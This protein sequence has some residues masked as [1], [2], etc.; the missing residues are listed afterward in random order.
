MAQASVHTAAISESQAAPSKPSRLYFIDHLRAALVILVVLHHVALVYGAS[1]PGYYYIEPPLT[2]PTAYRDLLVFALF[3]QAWFMGAFFLLAGYFT[4]GSLDRKGPATFVKERLIRLGI[5]LVVFIFVL[6]PIS[7]LGWFLMPSSLTGITNPPTIQ[8]YPNLIG[9]G[10]LWFVAMLLIFNFGYVG[11]RALTGNRASSSSSP[12]AP[13]YLLVGIFALLLA[14]ASYLFR[15][16]V[17]L[18]QSVNLFVDF[19]GFP[20]LAY[21]PQYLSFFVLGIV[22]SRG[23]WFRNLP[24]A[25]GIAGFVAAAVATIILFPLA[26]SGQLFSLELTAEALNNGMGNGHWQ[27]AAYALWDSITAVGLSIGL[28]TLFRR[29]LNGKGKLG[30]FL[31]QHS[32]AV[33]IIHIPIIVFLAYGLRTLELGTLLKF[34]VA[35]IIIVPVCYAA[36]FI[37]RKIPYVSRVL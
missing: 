20:T 32:Y 33:Y 11:W 6:S 2:D 23:D 4:P 9:L 30:T 25:M 31:G 34:G 5:P 19:L 24:N 16:I 17:P 1:V 28:I 8:S 21:L 22:A 3:N 15:M 26:F 18:G 27:S 36:A 37:V 29:F 12:A 14:G 7:N 35:S 10:P 13:G